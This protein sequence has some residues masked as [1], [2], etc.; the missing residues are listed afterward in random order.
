MSY[1]PTQQ[2]PPPQG[3]PPQQGYP[4]QGYQ[5][6]YQSQ[7]PPATYA[8][9]SGGPAPTGAGGSFD[10]AAFWKKLALAG[11]VASIAGIV[12]LISYFLT[13]YSV[14]ANSAEL[15]ALGSASYNGSFIADNAGGI[16]FLMW[17]VPL[18]AIAIIAGSILGALGKLQP[19]H[20]TYAILGGAGAALLGEIIFLIRSSDVTSGV[21]SEELKALGIS[22]GPSFGFYL[23]V[24]AT[25]A[26]GGV[27]A[28]FTFFKKPAA[29]G[30]YPQPYQQPAS[31]SQPN[32][33][34][35]ASYQQ[36]GQYPSQG[37]YPG[38]Q[39]YPPQQGQYP[40][41]PPYPGQ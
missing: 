30:G 1:D 18:G 40:G 10:F 7:P 22:A 5:Q 21:T 16:A 13:W 36:P 28:Y 3:Y 35:Q 34:Q 38:S 4:Q 6:G 14:S 37:A 41:Q 9:Y 33:Y 2:V 31:Y 8:Q 20:I 15:G 24:I 17:L 39:P 29:V 19:K 25:L 11:Q 26:A 32:S 23:A 27:Y 12:L